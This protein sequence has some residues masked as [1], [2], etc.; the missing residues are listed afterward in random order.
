[1]EYMGSS[2]RVPGPSPAR[3]IDRFFEYSVLGMLAS[4]FFAVLGSGFLDLPSA[5]I[6][7]SALIVRVLILTELIPFRAPARLVTALTVAYIG[8]YPVD[9]LFLSREF[10]PATVHLVLFLAVTKLL[11]ASSER[12]YNLVKI[13][14]F[15]ELLAA[16]IVS[17]SMNFF[18]FLGLFI[19]LAVATFASG[20]IRRSSRKQGRLV[21]AGLRSV[22]WRI[23]ALTVVTAIGILALTGGMFF[24]LP[25]TARAAFQRLAPDRFRLQGFSNE[26]VLGEIGEVK[27]SKT[28]VM[29]VRAL[30]ALSAPQSPPFAVLGTNLKWRGTALSHF[31]GRRWSNPVPLPEDSVRIVPSTQLIAN[32][33][34]PP[35]TVPRLNYEVHMQDSSSDVLFFA[36]VPEYLNINAPLVMRSFTGSYRVPF[37]LAQPLSYSAYAYLPPPEGPVSLRPLDPDERQRYLELPH[38]DLRI[39]ALA[40]EWTAGARTPFREAE[41]IESHL[42]KDF[43]YSLQLPKSQP[44]DPI[45]DFLFRR[46]QGHCEYFA[47]AMAVMLRTL[48]VP[49][50]VVTGFQSGEFNPISGWLVIRS[51]D[52]HSWVEAW[53]PRRGWTVFDPTPPDPNAGAVT[54]WTRIG[55]YFDAAETFWQEWVLNYNMDRQLLLAFKM[56][57]STRSGL[58]WMDNVTVSIDHARRAVTAFFRRWGATLAVFLIVAALG[59]YFGPRIRVT[60]NTRR[61]VLRVQR[62]QAQASD[63]TLLYNRMLN[64]LSRKGIEKPAWVTPVEFARSL[65][66]SHLTPL[67]EDLTAAYNDLRFG[68][69]REVAGRMIALLE[70]LEQA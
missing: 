48:G 21:R 28:P 52:A 1:M 40:S 51:S 26:V 66:P 34:R 39:T 3:N 69:R 17:G 11:T 23:A 45:S 68:S 27:T 20:E 36:G 61:R 4:G 19:I 30:D 43:R 2:G 65:P 24:I 57:T 6:M 47:S 29:R 25:R 50:R 56:Q 38:T 44:S 64:L 70:Q 58:S 7:V 67:I 62:G 22:Q 53:M 8:F 54:A 16:C 33:E 10:V 41:A 63:A 37:G 31:D 12:D 14:A 5:V 32:D 18:I 35:A 13:V 49:A 55:Y 9:Y 60:W 46:R 15:L 59:I 42:R